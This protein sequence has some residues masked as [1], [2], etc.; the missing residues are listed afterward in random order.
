MEGNGRNRASDGPSC[1]SRNTHPWTGPWD[2]APVPSLSFLYSQYLLK[3][4]FRTSVALYNERVLRMCENLAFCTLQK[5]IF[6]PHEAHFG[7]NPGNLMRH[8]P[9]LSVN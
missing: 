4:M 8:P 1:P 5:S 9:T 7:H 2:N 6:W 3:N